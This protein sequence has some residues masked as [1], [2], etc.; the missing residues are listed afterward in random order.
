MLFIWILGF[1]YLKYCKVRFK[2]QEENIFETRY[3]PQEPGLVTC[4]LHIN[5]NIVK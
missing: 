1:I 2:I 4:L 5:Q 3:T